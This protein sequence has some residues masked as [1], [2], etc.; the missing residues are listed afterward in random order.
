[1]DGRQN[2]NEK[3]HHCYERYYEEEVAYDGKIPI[4]RLINIVHMIFTGIPLFTT[5]SICL[6]MFVLLVFIMTR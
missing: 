5:P 6:W 2:F 4:L 3:L 1:M